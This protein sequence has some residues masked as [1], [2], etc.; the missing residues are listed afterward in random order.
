MSKNKTIFSCSKC[1]AQYPKWLGQCS[2]CG[3]WGTLSENAVTPQTR[4]V[5]ASIA[6]KTTGVVRLND[7]TIEKDDRMITKMHE[8]DRVFGGGIVKGSLTLLGG[9]PGIGKSTVVLQ[10]AQALNIPLLYASGEESAQQVAM[11]VKRLGF[12]LDAMQF[13]AT[14]EC[15]HI[16]S[17]VLAIKPQLVIVD[18]IQTMY[19]NTLPAEPG[20]ETQVR[21]CT[22]KLLEV[23]KQHNIAFIIIGHVTKEGSVAG[24]KTLEHLVDAVM[25][26]EESSRDGYRVLRNVKNRFGSTDEIGVFEMTAKG[27]VE[28]QDPSGI[29]ISQNTTNTDTIYSVLYEGSR[30]FMIEVQALVS[31]TPFGYPQRKAS[32]FDLNRLIML[33]AVLSKK[34]KVR[35][36][37][38]DVFLNVTGGLKVQETTAD[39]AVCLAVATSHNSSS[40]KRKICALGEV[41]LTGEVRAVPHIQKRID[42]AL[43]FGCDL[44]IVPPGVTHKNNAVQC[45]STVYAALELLQM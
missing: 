28:V 3:G 10:I 12:K 31:K 8:I 39:L 11:R 22:I 15:E 26:L 13:V 21:A 4:S 14:N 34:T 43:R 38:Q 5:T 44:I 45:V 19:T 17:N 35:L 2:E 1:D 7:I 33:C 23:A 18:S 36:D 9:H 30:P 37:T 40:Q 25:Y 6:P 29:F 27:I 24:P 42:E 41:G 20:S 16:I 32:G